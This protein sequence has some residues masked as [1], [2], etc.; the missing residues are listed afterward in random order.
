MVSCRRAQVGFKQLQI[1]RHALPDAVCIELHHVVAG[2]LSGM[3]CRERQKLDALGRS[4]R[5]SS[6]LR[7]ALYVN[8][9]AVYHCTEQLLSLWRSRVPSLLPTRYCNRGS[10]T[11]PFHESELH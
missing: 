8:L 11:A 4:C 7:S 1:K 5:I 10:V 3:Q 2:L 9:D 6:F